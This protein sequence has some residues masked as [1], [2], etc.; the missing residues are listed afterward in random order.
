MHGVASNSLQNESEH[1]KPEDIGSLLLEEFFTPASVQRAG[2][3]RRLLT[4]FLNSMKRQ[5]GGPAISTVG[6]LLALSEKQFKNHVGIG[7]DTFAYVKTTLAGY[8]LAFR[9]PTRI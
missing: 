3:P 7:S 9:N 5:F 6:D 4:M 1:E 8:G 2:F